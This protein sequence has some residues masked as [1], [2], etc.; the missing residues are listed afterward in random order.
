MAVKPGFET[1]SCSKALIQN[2]SRV[3]ACA[4]GLEEAW[5]WRR[6]IDAAV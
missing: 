2:L 4:S 1:L 6:K 3:K 5:I